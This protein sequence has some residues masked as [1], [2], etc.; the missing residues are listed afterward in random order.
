MIPKPKA[1]INV[2]LDKILSNA[3]DVGLP[4]LIPGID[5][6]YFLRLLAISFGYIFGI[7][8]A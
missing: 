7:I 3:S 2:T 5:E 4:G 1:P 8:D 6:P